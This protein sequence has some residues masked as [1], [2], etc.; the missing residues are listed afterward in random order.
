[1]QAET[2]RSIAFV[3]RHFWSIK[4]WIVVG[5]FALLLLAPAVVM[6]V[7]VGGSESSAENRVLAPF[8]GWTDFKQVNT[9]SRKLE[10]YV[11]DHFGLR[12]QLVRINSRMRYAMGVSSNPAQVVIGSNGWLFYARERIMEQ[13]VGADVFAPAELEAWVARMEANRK[14]L[15]DRGISFIIMLAPDKNTIY[16]ELLPQYPKKPGVLTRADQLSVRLQGSALTFIDPRATIMAAK[17]QHPRLYFEGDS[18]WGQRAAFIA[19]EMLTAEISKKFPKI[20]R[21]TL[22]DYDVLTGP[23]AIDLVYLLGLHRDLSFT[24]ENFTPKT[25]AT[26][27][28]ADVKRPLAGSSWGWPISFY[29]ISNPESPRAVIFGDSFTDYVLGPTFLY[30]TLNNPVFT[31]HNLGTFNFSLVKEVKPDI[32]IAVIAERY[33]KTIG[34]LPLGF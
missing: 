25:G 21:L 5:V 16:P 19:Y 12:E 10:T 7:P 28:V 14:W 2:N 23:V 26:S 33:L 15:A 1:M 8:P 18:H 3:Q 29:A 34:G 11:N 20:H 31:H 32:V 17:S 30:R 9:L 27:L 4:P 13:H 6:M 24:G 22:D